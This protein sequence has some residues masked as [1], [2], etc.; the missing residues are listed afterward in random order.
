VNNVGFWAYWRQVIVR[1]ASDA[2]VAADS[3]GV[4]PKKATVAFLIGLVVCM[5]ASA[6]WGVSVG[7]KI[8]FAVL[9]LLA[10][11]G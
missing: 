6:Y 3:Y 5:V 4:N 7:E 2:R 8:G 1:S 9:T 11:L 10:I